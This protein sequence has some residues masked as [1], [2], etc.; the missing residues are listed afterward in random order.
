LEHPWQDLQSVQR[1][2]TKKRQIAN[3]KSLLKTW[4]DATGNAPTNAKNKEAPEKLE[5]SSTYRPDVCNINQEP[6]D[7]E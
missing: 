7:L 1:K 2:A 5:E 3:G 4:P 6:I